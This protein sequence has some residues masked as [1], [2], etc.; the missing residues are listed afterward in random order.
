MVSGMT[1]S[2]RRTSRPGVSR[3]SPPSPTRLSPSRSVEP[4]SVTC[5]QSPP[6]RSTSSPGPPSSRSAPRPPQSR[7][8]PPR[9]TSVSLPPSPTITSGPAVPRRTSPRSV[10]TTVAERPSH[11]ATAR[12]LGALAASALGAAVRLQPTARATPTSAAARPTLI[13]IPPA[14]AGQEDRPSRG[15]MGRGRDRFG[16]GTDQRSTRRSGPSVV[17]V[18]EGGPG[19]VVGLPRLPVLPDALVLR[20][21]GDALRLRGRSVLE[22]G[23]PLEHHRLA[24]EPPVQQQ[25]APRGVQPGLVPAAT[26]AVVA[27]QASA[28][29]AAGA[30]PVL[31]QRT[32][33]EQRRDRAESQLLALRAEHL[34]LPDPEVEVVLGSG[35]L[36]SGHAATLGSRRHLPTGASPSCDRTSFV[37]LP[38]RPSHRRPFGSGCSTGAHDASG[39]PLGQVDRHRRDEHQHGGHDVDHGR[40]VGPEQVLEDPD[41]Q[42]LHL[43]TGGE[44][45]HHDL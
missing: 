33:A 4:S 9:P 31:G 43:G 8:R 36:L 7:S 2:A 27:V 45:G 17:A 16:R 6:P 30:A 15:Q 40:L 11:V 25:H 38:I 5:N 39:Q 35:L 10:P 28:L 41:R 18:E 19:P 21:P 24:H 3:S 32:G 29:E 37:S 13:A 22:G 42:R 34:P 1:S 14:D 44:R 20:G 12:V 26:H 23:E